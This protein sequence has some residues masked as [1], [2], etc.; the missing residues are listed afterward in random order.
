MSTIEIACIVRKTFCAITCSVKIRILSNVCTYMKDIRRMG[1]PITNR[2]VW[3]SVYRRW[4]LTRF[5]KQSSVSRKPAL[6]EVSLYK[7]NCWVWPMMMRCQL[8]KS[9]RILASRC[10]WRAHACRWPCQSWGAT[11]GAMQP[12]SH[13]ISSYTLLLKTMSCYVVRFPAT[14]CLITLQHS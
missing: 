4:S 1:E 2:R 7:T 14:R 10:S 9:S 5:C 12:R 3:A 13:G 6:Y 8:V 11:N